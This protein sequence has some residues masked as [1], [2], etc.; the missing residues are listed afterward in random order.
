MMPKNDILA[1][2][3]AV[4][5]G[6]MMQSLFEDERFVELFQKHFI[7]AWA[8]TNTMN[9]ANYDSATKQRTFEKMNAR[10]VFATHCQDVIE[11]GQMSSEALRTIESDSE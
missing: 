4:K 7:E 6:E 2:E 9:I 8:V 11:E 1:L 10:S 5:R 3:A